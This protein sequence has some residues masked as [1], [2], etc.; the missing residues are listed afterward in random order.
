LKSGSGTRRR[1]VPLDSVHDRAAARPV[2]AVTQVVSNSQI[3]NTTALPPRPPATLNDLA[4]LNFFADGNRQEEEGV[5]T[6]TDHV[7]LRSLDRVPRRWWPMMLVF[8]LLSAGAAAG[9][10]RLGFRPPADWQRS[11]IWQELHLPT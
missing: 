9:A 4:T 2:P 5:F 10:W 7:P 11:R 8:L 3:I 1:I 6:E